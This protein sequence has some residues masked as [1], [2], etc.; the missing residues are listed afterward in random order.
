MLLDKTHNLTMLLVIHQ[1]GF[2]K[3]FADRLCFFDEGR[4]AEQGNPVEVLNNPKNEG[5][6]QSLSAVLEAG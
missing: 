3:E 5:T 1:M 4:I 6:K 2:T